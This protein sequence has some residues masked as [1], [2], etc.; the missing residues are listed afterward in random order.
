MSDA[1]GRRYTDAELHGQREPWGEGGIEL[2]TVGWN[3]GSEHFELG[4]EENDGHT[5]VKVTLFRGRRADEATKDKARAQGVQLL[6][7]ISAPLWFIPDDGAQVLVAIPAGFALTPGAPMII[8]APGRNPTKQ[9]AKNAGKDVI[10]DLGEDRRLILKAGRGVILTDYEDRYLGLSPEMGIKCGDAD[11][12]GFALKAGKWLFYTAESGDATAALQ[13]SKDAIKINHND[14][15]VSA[16]HMKGGDVK[17]IGA[18][19]YSYTAGTYL[20]ALAVAAN[21]ALYGP[22]GAPVASTTVYMSP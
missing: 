7:R 21:T 10:L 1:R 13:L 19:F 8:G 5:L 11:A 2:G 9:F 12:C 16:L 22:P 3:D 14:G 6:C 17:A 15:K 18:N 20:G 4:T